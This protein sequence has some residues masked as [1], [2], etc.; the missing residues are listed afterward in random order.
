MVD[1]LGV[2]PGTGA[3]VDTD[4]VNRGAGSK[5]QQVVKVCLGADGT[6]EGLAGDD[7][8]VP[9]KHMAVA[10]G[11][12]SVYKDLDLD[13]TGINVKASAGQVYGWHFRNFSTAMI[14][15]KLFNK[16]TA[17]SVGTDVPY[18]TI[19]LAPAEVS[20]MPIPTGIEFDTGI[21]IGATTGL[22]DDDS[23]PPSLNEVVVTLFYK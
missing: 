22:A 4:E 23:G 1:G 19:P 8:P 20:E 14:Y 11:G 3:T 6:S 21:G 12:C 17:P 15:V 9:V 7:A 5:H 13:E 16:A 18:V 2:T 10:A